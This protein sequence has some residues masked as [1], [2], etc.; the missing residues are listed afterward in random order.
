VLELKDRPV[1]IG[2]ED[3]ELYDRLKETEEI[4]RVKGLE[5]KDI[6]IIAV[7]W[8]IRK[9]S[10]KP[11]Q[12]RD[13]GGLFRT[14]YLREEDEALLAATALYDASD[15]IL[16]DGEKVVKI[17]EEYA[18]GG[19]HELWDWVRSTPFEAFEKDFERE[20]VKLAREFLQAD[21]ANA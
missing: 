7:G 10:R 11:I 14:S 2:N 6:F 13:S 12:K 20:V 8:G 9:K 1:V 15:E 18:H 19:I 16:A 5:W 21:D 4:F 17:A 3:R